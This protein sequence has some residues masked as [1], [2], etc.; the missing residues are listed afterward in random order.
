MLTPS[1]QL[2]TDDF[3][4][5]HYHQN[6]VFFAFPNARFEGRKPNFWELAR[7]AG[8]VRFAGL[9]SV[10]SGPIFGRFRVVHEHVDLTKPEGKVALVETW[11]LCTWNIGGPDAGYWVW[12][13]T[14]T[15]RCAS[16]SP[17]L[18]P[19]YHYGGMAIRGS[20]KWY[21]EDCRFATSNGKT[22][23]DGNHDRARWTDIAGRSNGVW[24]G[25]TVM[26]HPKNFRFPEPVRIHPTM[27]YMVYTPVPLGDWT[28]EPGDDYVRRYRFLVHDGELQTAL[29]ER[30]WQ[31][32]A[33][34]PAVTLHNE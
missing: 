12:D 30:V 21:G 14:S 6:G 8:R 24:S 18:L 15:L 16:S 29:A 34:P 33:Q 13:L 3:P 10:A 4:P 26:T 25:V 22:R 27:P 20:R 31:D 28:L 2:V 9:K 32:F 17:L 23:K 5:D 7:G 1:G 11:D 19:K